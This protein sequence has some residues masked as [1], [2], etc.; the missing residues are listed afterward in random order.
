MQNH[1]FVAH[2]QPQTDQKRTA[3]TASLEGTLLL[4]KRYGSRKC[5]CLCTSLSTTTN[6]I[7]RISPGCCCCC[8]CCLSRRISYQLSYFQQSFCSVKFAS[9]NAS[10][11]MPYNVLHRRHTIYILWWDLREVDPN[12]HS[13]MMRQLPEEPFIGVRSSLATT[14]NPSSRHL[15]ACNNYFMTFECK[16]YWV[17]GGRWEFEIFTRL[18]MEN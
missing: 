17:T 1:Y 12:W 16:R 8:C 11:E 14:G 6:L 18:C 15:R 4:I 5:R 10:T 3:I 13:S 7:I 9:L 2:S